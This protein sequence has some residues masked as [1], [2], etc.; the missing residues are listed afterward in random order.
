MR[1]LLGV[2]RAIFNPMPIAQFLKTTEESMGEVLKSWK[3]EDEQL[4]IIFQHWMK[5]NDVV[6]DHASLREDLEGLKQEGIGCLTVFQ[7]AF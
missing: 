2:G 7:L 3:D 5:E 4:E 1:S 6:K